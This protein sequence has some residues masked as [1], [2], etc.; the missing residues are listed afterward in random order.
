MSTEPS[1]SALQL[2]EDIAEN[3]SRIE[4][5]TVGYDAHKFSDDGMCQDAVQHCLLRLSETA[6]LLGMT[7]RSNT[8]QMRPGVIYA[9]LAT[10]FAMNIKRLKLV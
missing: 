7:R 10:G 3:I 2:F 9:A 1:R 4:S 5:Y 8:H 6:R